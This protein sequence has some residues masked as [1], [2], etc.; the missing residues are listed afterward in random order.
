MLFFFIIY[1][2]SI[3]ICPANFLPVAFQKREGFRL[4][5]N[6]EEDMFLLSMNAY[7]L[8]WMNGYFAHTLTLDFN[9]AANMQIVSTMLF[10]LA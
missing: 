2:F 5:A 10:F 3:N 4:I 7:L 1:F 9:S 8:I 6:A